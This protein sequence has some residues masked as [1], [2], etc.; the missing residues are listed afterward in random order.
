MAM[1]QPFLVAEN[2][3]KGYGGPAAQEVLR[4]ISFSAEAGEFVAIRGPSGCGKS[5][6]L[7]I[8]G[9]MDR[10]SEGKVWLAGVRLDALSP[11]ELALVRRRRIGFVFQ[12][13]NLLPTLNVSENVSLPLLLDGVAE[14]E[15]RRRADAALAAVDLSACGR[16]FPS[17]LSGGEMQRVAIAR[18]LAIEPV[19]VIADEPTGSLD[20]AN[21]KRV[22]EL[23]A[24]L[25]A[26]RKITILM[27][28]HSDTAT[29]YASRVLHLKDGQLDKEQTA[30]VFSASV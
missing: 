20:S 10:P 29:A 14:R 7:H 23:L 2:L 27:A 11:R 22:L 17:Q 12:A 25:N 3:K 26:T 9:A 1:S 4:G 19:L 30:S 16:Q 6:L 24:E 28:T 8:L 15:C 21:G 13:F 18:A 5:T